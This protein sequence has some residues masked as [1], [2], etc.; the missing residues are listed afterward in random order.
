MTALVSALI[1]AVAANPVA[2]TPLIWGQFGLIAA[3]VHVMLVVCVAALWF[4]RQ[5]TRP[6][7]RPVPFDTEHRLAA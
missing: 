2:T 7:L 4:E 6:V 5:R 1:P 3:I